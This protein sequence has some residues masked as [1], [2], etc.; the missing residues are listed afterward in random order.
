MAL[1]A[2]SLGL[3]VLSGSAEAIID[4]GVLVGIYL[5]GRLVTMGYFTR[6]AWRALVA[7]VL[8]ILAG[9]AG[10]VALGAAQWLPG[11][12]FLSNSQRAQSTYT[13]F[14][15]GSL[16]LRQ[17]TLLA[18]PF[19]L[20]TNQGEPGP[21]AGRYNF[22]EV[23]SYVG[24]L[25][26]I[27]ACSLFL[28][29]FRTRP[30]AR[31]WWIWYLIA[32]VGLLSALGGQTPFGHVLYL[33]PGINSER[34]LNRNLLLVDF[35][36]AVLLAWWVH[37][38]FEPGRPRR[39]RWPRRRGRRQASG[40]GGGAGRRAEIVVTCLPLALIAAVCLFLWIGGAELDRLLIIEIAVTATDPPP[41]GRP[42]HRRGG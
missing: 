10:G 32:G 6:A 15:S 8:A 12:A 27:A 28:K 35:S 18:S 33:I 24:I 16:P 36:L 4:S 29:R 13:F 39:R 19:V 25:A 14:T 42:G 17:A 38:L 26:L 40:P 22:E 34:L 3:S 41:G 20:G 37:L 30:E 11:L 5:V 7:S 23:T 1:L 31:H 2:A 21:Y 9:V